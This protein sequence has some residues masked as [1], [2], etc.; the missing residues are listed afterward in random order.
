MH[1]RFFTFLLRAPISKVLSYLP[2]GIP[3]ILINRTFVHPKHSVSEDLNET[4][5]EF[6][7]T[8]LFDA[9]LLGFCDDITRMLAKSLFRPSDESGKS[10]N[11]KRGEPFLCTGEEKL[12]GK[13]KE[14]AFVC[15]GVPSERVL[16]FPGA[17]PI[18]ESPDQVYCEVAHCD[19]CSKQIKGTIYKCLTCF[20]YDLCVHCYKATHRQHFGGQHEFTT[21]VSS[22]KAYI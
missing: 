5:D 21:E 12:E 19:E 3:R 11:V 6:R 13:L 4:S 10:T 14:E 16:L 17:L 18:A 2:A 1:F 15:S 9:Y 7:E 22:D 8:Y 20:D